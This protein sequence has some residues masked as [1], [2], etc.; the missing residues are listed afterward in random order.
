MEN[1]LV[2]E[3]LGTPVPNMKLLTGIIILGM[4][5]NHL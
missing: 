5:M 3:A 1:S 4:E 2:F